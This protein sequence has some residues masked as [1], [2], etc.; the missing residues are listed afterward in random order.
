MLKVLVA[1]GVI[2]LVLLGW[3]AVEQLARRFARNHPEFGP[4]VERAGCGGNCK[5]SGG[6]SCQNH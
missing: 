6:G 2:L 3:V 4:Y 5:C 1:G